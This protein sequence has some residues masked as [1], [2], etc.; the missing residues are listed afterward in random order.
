M[1]ITGGLGE[2][3]RWL[4]LAPDWYAVMVAL[5]ILGLGLGMTY[6]FKRDLDEWTFHDWGFFLVAA[7]YTYVKNARRYEEVKI[8]RRS[9]DE[10]ESWLTGST[11]RQCL[12]RSE[13]AYVHHVF[14]RFGT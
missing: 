11:R 8:Q 12:N 5:I 13:I 6:H 9:G 10:N 4:I 2:T 1:A 3:L 7:V 14:V